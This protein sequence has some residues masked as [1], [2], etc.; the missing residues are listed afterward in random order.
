MSIADLGKLSLPLTRRR[1]DGDG[2]VVFEKIPSLRSVKVVDLAG[3]VTWLA[4][5][6]GMANRRVDEPYGLKIRHEKLHGRGKGTP[7]GMLPYGQCPL[8]GEGR[9]FLPAEMQ[10][11]APCRRAANG[12][13]IN[14]ENAC[15][16]IEALIERR[17]K[18][19]DQ[20]MATYERRMAGPAAHQLAAAQRQEAITA[21]LANAVEKLAGSERSDL[22]S[23]E[24]P[25]ANPPRTE[26]KPR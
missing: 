5:A 23:P 13:P 4:V 20:K 16:C 24:P 11:R 12:E 25:K 8:I 3:N 1:F 22:V 10:D 17:R 7:G 26:G 21:Q 19:N 14:D 2:G 15:T 6:N 18:T 9:R